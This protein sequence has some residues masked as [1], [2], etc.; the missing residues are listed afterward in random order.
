MKITYKT[1]LG[2]VLRSGEL[3]QGS[4]WV[5]FDPE[6]P[7]DKILDR[8]ILPAV[9]SKAALI[10]AADKSFRSSRPTQ[11]TDS[12]GVTWRRDG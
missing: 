6:Y 10:L 12:D 5:L 8:D 9:Q 4:K 7:A 1:F 11:Y 3:D 2:S